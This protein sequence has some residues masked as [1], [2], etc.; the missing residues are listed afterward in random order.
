MHLRFTPRKYM[1]VI[2]DPI[3]N[4]SPWRKLSFFICIRADSIDEGC[5]P[6]LRSRSN[7]NP[8]TNPLAPFLSDMEAAR[9]FLRNGP[10][11]WSSFTPKR[12]PRALGH[13]LSD[14][15]VAE[16]V[17]SEFDDRILL[18]HVPLR[19]AEAESFKGK[20][21]DLSGIDFSIDDSVLPE[22]DPNLAFG[23][24]SG[25]SDLPLPDFDWF[26]AD[27]PTDLDPPPLGEEWRRLEAVAEGS[28]MINGG[29]NI[30]SSDL[31][32]GNKEAMV[33][34][35]K[36]GKEEKDLAHMQ[37]EVLERESRL[38]RDHARAISRAE[39][40]GRREVVAVMS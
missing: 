7:P 25:S 12:V 8:Y 4:C 6:L 30:L 15:R 18:C 29:L 11:F 13:F 31:E 40:R 27:L 14:S 22:W 36:A 5:I 35:F 33:Y 34:H 17:D 24:D 10:F 2:R 21:V 19:G 37:K 3:L 32:E 20:G 38:A 16:D 28:H 1:S 39:T 26:F 23:D 9:D